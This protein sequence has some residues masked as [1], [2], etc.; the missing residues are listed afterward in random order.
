[1]FLR[2]GGGA[3]PEVIYNLL[4]IFKKYV[5]KIKSKS[6]SR[7]LV[8]LQGKLKL[9]KKKFP[10]IHMFLLYFQHAIVLSHHF[11]SVADLGCGVNEVKP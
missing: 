3:D 9:K 8:R 6:P 11:I 7:H 1:M 2:A 4:L 5:M 10:H